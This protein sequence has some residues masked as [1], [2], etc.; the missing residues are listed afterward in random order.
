MPFRSY[1]KS[2]LDQDPNWQKMQELH[3]RVQALE[4]EV[5]ALRV[6]LYKVSPGSA[7][8]CPYCGEHAF[9]RESIGPMNGEFGRMGGTVEKLLCKSCMKTQNRIYVPS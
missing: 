1:I 8:W 7:A 6:K 3:A 9:V 4:D 5:N 2:F